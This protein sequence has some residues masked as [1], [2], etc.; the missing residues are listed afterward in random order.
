MSAASTAAFDAHMMSIALAMA[1]RGLGSTAPNPSVGAVIADEV[2]GE[3]IARGW[4][5]PGGRPHAEKEAL[6]RAGTRARGKTMYVT[7]EPC[8]HTGRVPTCSDSVVAAGIARVVCALPDPNHIVAGHGFEQLRE[9]GIEIDVGLFGTRARWVTLG[10]IL[11]QTEHRPFVQIKMAVSADGRIAKGGGGAPSWVTGAEARADGHLLRAEADAILV[12]GGT[13]RADDPDLTCRLPGLA[14]RSPIRIVLSPRM[15]LP[16]DAKLLATSATTPVWLVTG[17]PSGRADMDLAA[18][19]VQI[20]HVPEA[21]HGAGGIPAVLHTLAVKGITRLLI[22]GGPRT[23]T[24]CLEAGVVDEAV[25]YQSAA[26]GPA[27][28]VA[29]VKDG[30]LDGYFEAHG[31]APIST[32]SVGSDQRH[33]FRRRGF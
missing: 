10:H 7:L 26:R 23:W 3:M 13:V 16:L 6:Y 32:T 15:G 20:V 30:Q 14:A 19:G 29:V 2:T 9:A 11:R 22:E 8:A 28:G 31:L 5:Q 33:I 24:H 25:V 12:G 4:T 18:R 21:L 17:A 1:R 27:D